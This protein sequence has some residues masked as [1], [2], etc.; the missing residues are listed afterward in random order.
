MGK[1]ADE[2]CGGEKQHVSAK[3]QQTIN[4]A[5]RC[6]GMRHALRRDGDE[7]CGEKAWESRKGNWQQQKLVEID[8][9]KS[10]LKQHGK[11]WV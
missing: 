5:K 8:N 9:D 1:A 10:V 4:V 2:T 11:G 7:G 6:G 3:Q